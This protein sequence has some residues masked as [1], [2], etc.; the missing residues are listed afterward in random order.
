MQTLQ[1]E[2]LTSYG[3]CF[4]RGHRQWREG[5]RVLNL[6][7]EGRFDHCPRHAWPQ[8]VSAHCPA[9]HGPDNVISIRVRDQSDQASCYRA[10]IEQSASPALVYLAAGVRS[11]A[12]FCWGHGPKEE[13]RPCHL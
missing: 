4:R 9:M 5:R 11:N 1:L 7:R 8:G 10:F 2:T 3:L 13:A 12:S 6:K